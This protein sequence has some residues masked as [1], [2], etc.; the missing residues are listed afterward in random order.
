MKNIASAA[1]ILLSG[2]SP[3]FAGNPAVSPVINPDNSVTFTVR[4]PAAEEVSVKGS[5]IPRK[6]LLR[7]KAG[8]ISKEAKAKMERK[9][10][11]WTFTTPPLSPDLYTYTFEVDEVTMTDSLNRN[12]VRDVADTLSYFIIPGGTADLYIDSARVPH[13]TVRDVWYPSTLPGME[14]RRMNVYLPPTYP[15]DRTARFPVLYLL[16]GSGGD[17]EAWRDC[18]RAIQILDNMIASG[19][20]R[21]MI[22]VMPN[23]NVELAAAPGKDPS[24]PDMKSSAANAGSMLGKFETTFMDDIV[25]YVDDNFRTIPEKDSRAIAGISLGGL[26]AMFISMNNPSVFDYVGL[27]SAQAANPINDK[28]AGMQKIGRKWKQL[29]GT[30]PFLGGGSVDRTISNMT[31]DD[32]S[33]YDDIDSKLSAQFAKAPRLYYIALG[34]D[35]FVKKL[36]DDL[37]VKMDAAGYKYVYNESDGGHSWQNWRR[38]LVDFLPRL[39]TGSTSLGTHPLYD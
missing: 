23:G 24:R 33:I 39:F 11:V 30:L 36:N 28:V 21:P 35:D 19:Q 4:K 27:F 10:D 12:T 29:K 32:L 6:N 7:T 1:F 37:R 25:S 8:T 38:Y 15:T 34:S 5:F 20:C 14:K 17:E 31:S 9:D 18:G 3:I 26:H 16:H 2:L 13:G 22:V